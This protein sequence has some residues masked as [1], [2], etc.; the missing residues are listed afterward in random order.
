M[1]DSCPS[2]KVNEVKEAGYENGVKIGYKCT[3]YNG[4]E[5]V[6]RRVVWQEN[7]DDSD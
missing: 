5:P 3:S 4:N 1:N 2:P 7:S 6:W